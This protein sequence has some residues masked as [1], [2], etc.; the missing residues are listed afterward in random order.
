MVVHIHRHTDRGD[1]CDSARCG[2]PTIMR[3]VREV[4]PTHNP[5]Q[6]HLTLSSAATAV[7]IEFDAV[8]T[9]RIPNRVL[10][11]TTTEGSMVGHAVLIQFDEHDA[12]RTRLQIR[13]SYNPPGGALTH[14]VL[15]LLGTDPKSRLDEDLV[16]MKTALETCHLAHDA[17]L[18]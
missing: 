7:P 5:H 4:R 12:D 10:A 1:L 16:R 14:R 13:L 18:R 9:E 3:H 15:S 2:L 8:V 11:W 17:V 6:W